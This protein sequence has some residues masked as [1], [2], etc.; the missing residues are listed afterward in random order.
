MGRK[1]RRTWRRVVWRSR[2]EDRNPGYAVL[3]EWRACPVVS[4]RRMKKSVAERG[5]LQRAGTW[6]VLAGGSPQPGQ[7]H[8]DEL[9]LGVVGP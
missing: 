4:G 7:A 2:G 3:G 1:N 8:T 5:R 9:A 6:M